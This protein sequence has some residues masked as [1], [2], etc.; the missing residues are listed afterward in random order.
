MMEDILESEDFLGEDFSDL[1]AYIDFAYG[2]EFTAW[3]RVDAAPDSAGPASSRWERVISALGTRQGGPMSGFFCAVAL[4]RVLRKARDAI[5]EANGLVRCPGQGS[6]QQR[7]LAHDLAAKAGDVVSYHDDASLLARLIV[8]LCKSY[9]VYASEAVQR[10]GDRR[11]ARR[12][13]AGFEGNSSCEA[14]TAFDSM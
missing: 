5:D 11:S 1:A 12:R 3:F 9:G 10:T 6:A 2:E 8:L 14:E 4:I 13:H 7:K